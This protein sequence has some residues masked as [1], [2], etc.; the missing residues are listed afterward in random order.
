M[1][2]LDIYRVETRL[3]RHLGG[4]D[5]LLLQLFQLF[6]GNHVHIGQAWHREKGSKLQR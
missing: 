3:R 4:S 2:G 1:T 5:E 6:I